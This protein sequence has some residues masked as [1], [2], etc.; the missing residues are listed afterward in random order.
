MTVSKMSFR[1]QLRRPPL[2]AMRGTSDDVPHERRAHAYLTEWFDRNSFFTEG[3]SGK[4]FYSESFYTEGGSSS[5]SC[6]RDSHVDDAITENESSE[7]E[8]DSLSSG[9]PQSVSSSLSDSASSSSSSSGSDSNSSFSSDGISSLTMATCLKNMRISTSK[10]DHDDS[11]TAG[12]NSY[13]RAYDGP[14][15]RSRSFYEPNRRKSPPEDGDAPLLRCPRG[16]RRRRRLSKSETDIDYLPG[17][18][19]PF[20]IPTSRK[21]KSKSSPGEDGAPPP[22]CP[23]SKMRERRLS[24]S[25]TDVDYLPGALK[26]ANRVSFIEDID[27]SERSG[28]SQSRK[29]VVSRL[30]WRDSRGILGQYT[31]KIN[32]RLQPH[33]SGAL[34]FED[35]TATTSIWENGIPVRS[36]CPGAATA[37]A[38]AIGVDKSLRRELERQNSDSAAISVDKCLRQKL[39]QQSSDQNR[40]YLPHLELGDTGS[41][42]DMIVESGDEMDRLRLHDLRLHDFAFIQR[43]DGR[44]TYAI[45]ADRG[46]EMMRFVVDADG[47]TKAFSKRRWSSSIRLVNPDRAWCLR[48]TGGKEE[49]EGVTARLQKVMAARKQRHHRLRRSI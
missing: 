27:T 15:M 10:D 23:R 11:N 30:P 20:Y 24:R 29:R 46:Y 18:S 13:Q 3:G 43:S 48:G 28:E 14:R 37:A 49:E 31:G 2:R 6:D 16:Q 39:G 17:A 32:D 5:K 34:I 41:P 33:G 12:N 35:G 44:W 9:S 36:W 38:A 7:D 19:K 42:Q 4:S 22:R 21:S 8:A 1:H 47:N 45:I 26:K 25:E 40:T